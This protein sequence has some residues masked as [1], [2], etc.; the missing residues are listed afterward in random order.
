MQLEYEEYFYDVWNTMEES[1]VSDEYY[2]KNEDLFQ[3]LT[4][5]LYYQNTKSL[6]VPPSVARVIIRSFCENIAT[7]G[8]R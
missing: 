5:D 8:L 2:S 3:S 6:D 1:I 4:Y 7:F